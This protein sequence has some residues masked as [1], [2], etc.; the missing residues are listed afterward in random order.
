MVFNFPI[1]RNFYD[2]KHR[3]DFTCDC[4]S[5]SVKH[6]D[7]IAIDFLEGNFICTKCGARELD[8]K[9]LLYYHPRFKITKIEESK[10][11]SLFN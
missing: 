5:H 8:G 2:G 1:I 10:Q 9:T 3:I 7:D 6:D 11:L 4:G